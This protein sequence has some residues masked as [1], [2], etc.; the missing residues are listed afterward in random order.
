MKFE[1][2]ETHGGWILR[3]D[4]VEISRFNT[5]EQALADIGLRL[6]EGVDVELCYSVGVRYLQ[7][8]AV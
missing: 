8:G 4:G 3:R 2:I 1:V 6:R 5:Q 7:R